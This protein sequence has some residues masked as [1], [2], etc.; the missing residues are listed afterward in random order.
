MAADAI[1]RGFVL[2]NR[3]M[4][5]SVN[6]AREDFERGVDDLVK[7]EAVFPGWLASLLNVPVH[8][9]ESYER[10]LAEL[11]ENREAI[12]V[13]IEVAA[14]QAARGGGA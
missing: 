9:L 1:N 5:G 2:G 8:G 6:A 3:V 13:Y 14:E 11:F 12:K 10:L 7:A 4:V